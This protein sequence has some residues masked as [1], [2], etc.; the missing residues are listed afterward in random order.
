MKEFVLKYGNTKCYLIKGT[1]KNILIDT[2][3]AGTLPLFFKELGKQKLKIQDI[4][5]LFITHY[6]PDHMGIA[7]NL[8]DYGVNLV[9]LDT[10]IKYIH[11]SDYIFQRQPKLK[12][13]PIDDKKIILLKVKNSKS[14]LKRCGIA[15][16]ILSTPGHSNCSVSYILDNGEAFVG[17]LYPIEQVAL[18][19]NPTI[20]NSWKKLINNNVK[21]VH[22]A[23]YN[24]EILSN[25]YEYIVN[26][27][28]M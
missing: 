12:F 1:A 6:H 16:K 8:V 13:K 28:K 3:W 19:N 2:D 7:Q 25:Y 5:Y 18:Y 10:Q 15:G 4:D 24:D 20:T 23:H 14:F 11:Q 26:L 17:D 9:V 21:I 22:F 27:K